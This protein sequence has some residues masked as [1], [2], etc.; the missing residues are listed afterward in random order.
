MISREKQR[1]PVRSLEAARSSTFR[2]LAFSRA[3]PRLRVS[4]K[5]RVRRQGSPQRTCCGAVS[6]L[7][8]TFFKSESGPHHELSFQGYNSPLFQ[9]TS[10]VGACARPFRTRATR[11]ARAPFRF[12]NNSIDAVESP[13]CTPCMWPKVHPTARPSSPARA[14]NTPSPV[15]RL[16]PGLILCLVRFVSGGQKDDHQKG[17]QK[18]YKEE[19]IPSELIAEWESFTS[20]KDLVINK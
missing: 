9:T 13:E 2:T 12:H 17:I 1:T 19:Y 11:R 14:S 4:V 20:R 18:I 8:K 3:F 16:L 10:R 15:D 7:D 6:H 5:N